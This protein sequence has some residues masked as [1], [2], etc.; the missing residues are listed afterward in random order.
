MGHKKADPR[1]HCLSV[2]SG[3][4]PS[5]RTWS[6]CSNAIHY[7]V[8]SPN[9]WHTTGPHFGLHYQSARCSGSA[10]RSTLS[11]AFQRSR[12]IETPN[13]IRAMISSRICDQ[14][15]QYCKETEVKPFSTSTMKRLLDVC[16]ATIR[17]SLQGLDYIS[18]NWAKAFD[19]LSGVPCIQTWKHGPK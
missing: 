12:F 15:R 9:W 18:A 16:T 3:Q 19:D 13:V 7:N 14:Y 6:W 1:T 10:I 5:R 17:K 11:E 4:T 2:W 8:Q